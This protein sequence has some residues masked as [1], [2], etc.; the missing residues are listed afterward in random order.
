MA[1]VDRLRRERLME[2][3]TIERAFQ[4]APEC[5][6]VD[7]LR[8]KLRK[9]GHFNVDAH[10]QGGSIRKELTKRLKSKG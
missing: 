4:L 3:G 7:E 2:I 8:F 1:G 5:T 9:E 6:S 10:L